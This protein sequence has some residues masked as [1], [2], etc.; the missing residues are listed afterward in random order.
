M[1]DRRSIGPRRL[2]DRVG[3]RDDA[4][5]CVGLSL[6]IAAWVLLALA[7]RDGF[8]AGAAFSRALRSAL[9][10][11]FMTQL[12]AARR[13][14]LEQQIHSREWLWPFRF[15]RPV[16]AMCATWRTRPR[17]S[18]PVGRVFAGCAG[19]TPARAA[20]GT[21]WRLDDGP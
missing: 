3:W 4:R 14:R 10:A 17:V 21:W 7:L 2:V 20:A 6:L 1:V 8:D 13:I 19:A 16:C 18:G 11:D 15:R 9:G 12:P 5:L